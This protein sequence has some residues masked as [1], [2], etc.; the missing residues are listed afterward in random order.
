MERIVGLP[1]VEDRQLFFGEAFVSF[2][3]L[4]EAEPVVLDGPLHDL[5]VLGR[6]RLQDLQTRQLNVALEL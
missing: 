4:E 2:C 1:R 6:R 3:Q 5:H